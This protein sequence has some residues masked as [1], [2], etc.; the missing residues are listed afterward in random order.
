MIFGCSAGYDKQRYQEGQRIDSVECSIWKNKTISVYEGEDLLD[1]VHTGKRE[2][3]NPDHKLHF[4]CLNT[5]GRYAEEQE[6]LDNELKSMRFAPMR[7]LPLKLRFQE[8][9]KMVEE[10]ADVYYNKIDMKL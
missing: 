1:E 10:E 7:R 9:N 3:R 8:L 4:N 6:R 2:P 5:I